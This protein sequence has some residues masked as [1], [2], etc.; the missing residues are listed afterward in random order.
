MPLKLVAPRIGKT[1]FWSVRGTHLGIH[2]DRSTKTPS[3]VTAGKLLS[4]WKAEIEA[5]AVAKPG[6]PTFLDAA[7]KYMAH[8]GD[9]RFLQPITDKIGV[10]TL[11][12]IDQSY[13]DDVVLDLFPT[14]GAAT[15][16][17]QFYTPVSAVLKQ[18]GFDWQVKRPKG[19]RGIATTH[20][21]QPEQA[22]LIFE[23]AAKV[24]AEFGIFL[25][26]LAYSGAR[27]TEATARFR[28]DTLSLRDQLGYIDF[29]KNK[30]PRPVFLPPVLVAALASHPRGLD[31]PGKAVFR[32]RKNGRIYTLLGKVRTALKGRVTVGGFHVFCHTYGAWMRRYAGLDTSGLVATQ[33]WKDAASARRY[34][35]LVASEEAERATMLPVA[36]QSRGESVERKL[37]R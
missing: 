13:L 22:F 8:G 33:R 12:S 5:G 36:D 24:D 4:K 15:R 28:C 1:P 26:F 7:V 29:G 34:E 3:R 20:W 27:L 23:E 32:F 21:Y 16:N 2:V 19:W 11:K 17:R 14:A 10:R 9:Q 31:R 18:A 6:E 25:Q 37:R 35:H 30:D